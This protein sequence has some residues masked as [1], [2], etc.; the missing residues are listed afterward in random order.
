MIVPALRSSNRHDESLTPGSKASLRVAVAVP[1][2]VL[3]SLLSRAA[4][5]TRVAKQSVTDK[6]HTEDLPLKR[7]FSLLIIALWSQSLVLA[8]APASGTDV[9]K[10]IQPTESET[11]PATD[12]E[13][14]TAGGIKI[15]AGTPIEVEVAYTVNSLDVKPGES[16]SFRVLVPIV[17]DG[18]TVI[19]EGAL[20][21]ARVIKSKRGGHWGKAGKLVWS[22]E[23]V[24]G[25]DKSRIP[26]APEIST[27]SDKIWSLENKPKEAEKT[28]GK[29]N[30]TSHA[31][32]VAAMSI[33]TGA[34]F[35]PLALMGGFKRGEN[36]VLREGRRYVVTVGKDATVKV[37]S[38]VV[39][40]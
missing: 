15:P 22:M 11:A 16:I 38:A 2:R 6:F 10:T 23:D 30:G 8:Q 40:P 20:V 14:Q 24:V 28:Q 19:E 4:G 5:G 12:S 32:Q 33:L 18:V 29:V 13:H 9:A 17:I 1:R 26:L 7:F 31:G 39:G 34:L 25:A 3:A 21:T 35:P 27:R 37:V 36:A